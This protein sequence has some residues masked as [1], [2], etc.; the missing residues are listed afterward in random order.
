[1]RLRLRGAAGLAL[2]RQHPLEGELRLGR[3]AQRCQIHLEEASVSREHAVFTADPRGQGCA[4]RRISKT[5]PL[6]V[7]GHAVD[8]AWLVAG[9][10][11]QA[12]TSVFVVEVDG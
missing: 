5:G 9:D 7:N 4:V 2:G 6:Y 1:V 3:D 8:E 11:V 10:Q 12:G